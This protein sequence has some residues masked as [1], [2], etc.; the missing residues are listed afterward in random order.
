MLAALI[1]AGADLNLQNVV[2]FIYVTFSLHELVV[3]YCDLLQNGDTPAHS[4]AESGRAKSL[5]ALIDAG[6]DLNLQNMVCFI[7]ITLSLHELVV[8]Y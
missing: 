4:A 8:F 2:C 3:F 6:A 1:D 7:Y 5:A